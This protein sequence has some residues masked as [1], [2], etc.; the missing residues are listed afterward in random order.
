[1][2]LLAVIDAGQDALTQAID[3]LDQMLPRQVKRRKSSMAC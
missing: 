3:D 2:I 1:V